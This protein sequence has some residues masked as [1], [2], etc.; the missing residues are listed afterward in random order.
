MSLWPEGIESVGRFY[1][2]G[3]VNG[4]MYREAEFDGPLEP[5][6][7]YH[8]PVYEGV[9]TPKTLS[10]GGYGSG[11][12]N[13]EFTE[14]EESWEENQ[15][16]DF[17]FYL[18]TEEGDNI[19]F[20]LIPRTDTSFG[21]VVKPF[22]M[23]EAKHVPGT[24]SPYRQTQKLAFR[25]ARRYEDDVYEDTSIDPH[26]NYIIPEIDL[27]TAFDR[28]GGI[29]DQMW[30]S[31]LDW[32]RP[33]RH[34]Y[35]VV[36]D[37]YDPDWDKASESVPMLMNFLPNDLSSVGISK[38]ETQLAGL[39]I[40]SAHGINLSFREEREAEE[41]MIEFGKKQ[42]NLVNIDGEF[43]KYASGRDLEIDNRL[44]QSQIRQLDGPQWRERE[45][46]I[47][48]IYD[49]FTQKVEDDEKDWSKVLPGALPGNWEEEMPEE[50]FVV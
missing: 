27:L 41:L 21:D 13:P 30:E 48:Q 3:E 38:E 34:H 9:D 8:E 6:R 43:G 16:A 35:R 12:E 11:K 29:Q 17:Y 40:A 50:R 33:V 15:E 23:M 44:Y 26:E 22:S 45:E 2:D 47:K 42:E 1:L 4:E 32:R 7:I 31:E 37:G 36:E 18:D 49:D 19:E 28:K 10:S 5:F 25:V 39:H 14:L 20:D 46:K 24:D